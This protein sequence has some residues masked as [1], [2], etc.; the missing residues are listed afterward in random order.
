MYG[1]TCRDYHTAQLWCRVFMGYLYNLEAAPSSRSGIN[2]SGLLQTSLPSKDFFTGR[3]VTGNITKSRL[4]IGLFLRYLFYH[5]NGWKDCIRRLFSS[6]QI[7]DAKWLSKL[8][9]FS[10]LAPIFFGKYSVHYVHDLFCN[11]YFSIV[12]RWKDNHNYRIVQQSK[13]VVRFIKIS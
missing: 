7:A 10:L 11:V 5:G 13:E 8:C 12:L 1:V 4:F 3:T 2:V 9:E 6:T